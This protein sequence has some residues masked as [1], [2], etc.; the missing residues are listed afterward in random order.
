MTPILGAG[1]L[2]IFGFLGSQLAR[3]IKLPAVTGYLVTGIVLG[4]SAANIL[5]VETVGR[6]SH[7]TTPVVLGIIAYMIGG[8]LP[9]SKLHGLKRSIVLITIAE[10][11]CAWL[12]VLAIVTFVAPLVLPSLSLD[13][14][15]YLT[16]GIVIGGISLATAPAVT[17]AIIEETKARGSLPT[18]LLGVVALDDALA[19]IAFAISIGVG[20]TLLSAEVAISPIRLLVSELVAIGLSVVLGVACSIILLKLVSFARG[21]REILAVVLGAV[22]LSAELSAQ[23]D[24]FPLITN[25]AMGFVVI[26]RQQSSEDLVEVTHDIQELI[27]VLFFTLAGAHVDLGVMGSAGILATLIVLG[28]CTGKVFG[29]WLGATL[30]GASE[31]V[32][33]YLGLALMPKAGVTVGLTLLV[34]ETPELQ[35][36][37]SLVVSGVLAS[38]LI[39]E[40]LSPPLSKFA[41]GKA[42]KAEREMERR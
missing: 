31:V 8:S 7:V 18:T 34:I 19:V 27:F 1:G 16:M 42:E 9:L 26:N 37:S 5:D 14:R 13:F 35:P 20:A 28:R 2:I 6:L 40:L 24:F 21:R 39:N 32:R 38:T 22:I 25:M 4:P 29:A 3:R 41:L 23:L 36:I 15:S 33:K 17:M 30:S 12:F 10:G 11:S